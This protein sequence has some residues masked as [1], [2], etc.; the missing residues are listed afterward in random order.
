MTDLIQLITHLPEH[1]RSL[2][3]AYGMG[4]YVILFLIIFAETGLVIAPFLPGDTLL[5]ATGALLSLQL[6][7][8]DLAAMMIVLSIAAIVGDAL[9]YHVGRWLAPKIFKSPD[10]RWLNKKQL[11]RTHEF[12]EKH[13]GKTIIFARFLPFIRTYAP[14]VAGMSGMSYSKFVLFNIV[15]GVV[16]ITSLL[17]LGYFFGELPVVKSNFHLVLFGI[18]FVSFL[19]VVYE[20]VRARTNPATSK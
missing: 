14:F 9:N 19:P 4:L 18:M 5:F 10:S 15:G 12:Y 20:F 17:G 1:L 8:L 16:W 13:G 3:E 7:N 2:A 6:P 11:E